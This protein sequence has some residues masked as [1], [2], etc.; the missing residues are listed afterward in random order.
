M[1]ILLSSNFLNHKTLLCSIDSAVT[2]F[3]ETMMPSDVLCLLQ[4]SLISFCKINLATTRGI[5]SIRWARTTSHSMNQYLSLNVAI[6]IQENHHRDTR[7]V[8]AQYLSTSQRSR[9]YTCI[10]INIYFK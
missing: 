7:N 5:F 8:N 9:L 1:T 6:L 10:S 2:L 3:M 4:D